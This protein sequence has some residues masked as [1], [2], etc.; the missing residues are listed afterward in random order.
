[1]SVIN[2]L[3]VGVGGQ[4][5]VLA[6][7]ILS[8]GLAE[9]D[10]DVKV[11]EIHGMSQRGGSVFTQIRFADDEE[12]YSPVIEKGKANYLIAFEKMEALRYLE[13]LNPRG[14]VIV[15]DVELPS[16][17][18]QAGLVEYPKGI[19]EEISSHVD[20]TIIRAT[21][22]AKEL[23]NEKVMNIVLL[24]VLTKLLDLKKIDWKAAIAKKVKPKFVE[25]NLNAF[26]RGQ[27]LAV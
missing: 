18:I 23:G 27:E 21:E 8:E 1:M 19:L 26:D 24:S 20:T 9:A 12:V 2:V 11:S 15:N 10:Y 6:G 25:I 17:P 5:I 22:I 7:N 4:G 13:M 16:A 3:M 14:K